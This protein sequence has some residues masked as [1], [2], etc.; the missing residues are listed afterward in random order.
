VPSPSPPT[1]HAGLGQGVGGCESGL[2][3]ASG[4]K[5]WRAQGW[6]VHSADGVVWIDIP[7]SAACRRQSP[8]RVS[9]FRCLDGFG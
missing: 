8:A 9:F 7:L 2:K 4:S 6:I 1:G 5:R 3:S